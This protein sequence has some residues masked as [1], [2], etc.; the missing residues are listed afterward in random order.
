MAW[1]GLVP[2]LLLM[3]ASPSA[4]EAAVRGWW[5]GTGFLLASLYWLAPNLGPGLLLV[6]ACIGVAVDRC[7]RRHLGAAARRR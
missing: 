3:R 7:R 6:A 1:F 5:F 2:G 4:R